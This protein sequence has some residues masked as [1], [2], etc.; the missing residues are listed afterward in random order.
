MVMDRSTAARLGQETVTP[1]GAPRGAT[2]VEVRN[3]TT[4]SAVRVVKAKT[5]V[6]AK[7]VVKASRTT[8]GP[9]ATVAPPRGR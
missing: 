4:S 8:I 9:G 3:E 5:V 1:R 6:K 7:A 2:V